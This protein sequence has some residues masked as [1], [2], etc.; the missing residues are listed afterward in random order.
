MI[1]SYINRYHPVINGG[2]NPTWYNYKDSESIE[3]GDILVL[4]RK[5]LAI[6]CSARNIRP[7]Y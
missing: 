5:T 4:N 1:L 3:G 2:D 6:G 7:G